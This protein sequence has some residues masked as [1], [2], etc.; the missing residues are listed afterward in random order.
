[1]SHPRFVLHIVTTLAGGVQA[2]GNPRVVRGDAASG[3]DCQT[4]PM[5]EGS[6]HAGAGT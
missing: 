3:I 5:T 2:H 4:L 6:R 1:M